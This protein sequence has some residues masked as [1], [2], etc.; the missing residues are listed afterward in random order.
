MLF[1]PNK[2]QYRIFGD[3]KTWGEQSEIHRW[4]IVN[5]QDVVPVYEHENKCTYTLPRLINYVCSP[6]HTLKH[7]HTHEHMHKRTKQTTHYRRR[8]IGIVTIE[9]DD[10]HTSVC[11]CYI[12]QKHTR[13]V[14]S[15]CG[16][17]LRCVCCF[18]S[19]R[20]ALAVSF[21]VE[22]A[23]VATAIST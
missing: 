5:F 7:T 2:I 12:Q 15:W 19:G 16:V 10:V 23:V 21:S 20:I 22:V 18:S 11:A 1:K 4:N 14:R 17:T 13:Y 8:G 6:V 9:N 3:R